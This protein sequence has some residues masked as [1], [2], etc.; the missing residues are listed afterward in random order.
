MT[1]QAFVDFCA[2]VSGDA[3]LEK[4]IEAAQTP[5]DIIALGSQSGFVFSEQDLKEGAQAA[6]ERSERELS[7][8]ELTTVSGGWFMVAL[9]VIDVGV[10]V[11]K[12]GKKKKWW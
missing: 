12:L 2:K 5:A 11:F 9:T 7:E 6:A 1:S 8:D 10:S 4:L 3:E